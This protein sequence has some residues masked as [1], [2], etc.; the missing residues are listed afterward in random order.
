MIAEARETVTQALASL[1]IPVHR[2]SPGSVVPPAAVLVW[3]SPL[4]EPRTTTRA[5]IGLEVRVIVS[6]AS[7]PASQAALDA[8]VDQA[9]QALV[10]AQGI[11]VDAVSAP[12][13]DAESATH[14]AAIAVYVSIE[15]T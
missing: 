4:Y 2:Y 3:G 15:R 9:V 10:T 5:V 13:P 6:S 11:H 8:L 7:G 14:T 1:G 12:T